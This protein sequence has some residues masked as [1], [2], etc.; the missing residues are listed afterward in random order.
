MSEANWC[1]AATDPCFL[2]SE[3]LHHRGRA[4]D[5]GAGERFADA[6]QGGAVALDLGWGFSQ[7]HELRA[8]DGR[9]PR[10]G[11]VVALLRAKP[12]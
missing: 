12:E 10:W 7:A 1:D 6:P 2:G 4:F 3:T 9:R 8:T 11:K 5:H